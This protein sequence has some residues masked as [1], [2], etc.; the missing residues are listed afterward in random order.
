MD[1]T[2]GEQATQPLG[3]R[4]QSFTRQGEGSDEGQVDSGIDGTGAG[5]SHVRTL[6]NTCS[7]FQ[8]WRTSELELEIAAADARCWGDAPGA[9]ADRLRQFRDSFVADHTAELDQLSR[10]WADYTP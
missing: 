3:N 8:G 4:E 9:N 10:F 1:T 5:G 2:P 7:L 6:S